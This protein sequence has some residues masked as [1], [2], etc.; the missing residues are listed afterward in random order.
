MVI[1]N[2]VANVN[3]LTFKS[4][5]INNIESNNRDLEIK[6]FHNHN[7]II[8]YLDNHIKTTIIY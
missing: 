8:R 5:L 1:F 2:K 7:F 3:S 4:Q 6:K